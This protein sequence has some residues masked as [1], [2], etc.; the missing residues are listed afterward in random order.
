MT[1]A[2]ALPVQPVA[3]ETLKCHRVLAVDQNA[4]S[5]GR[6]RAVN[7][8]CWAGQ[9]SMSPG[10]RDLRPCLV[11]TGDQVCQACL[12]TASTATMCEVAVNQKLTSTRSFC[13]V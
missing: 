8:C 9:R 12:I 11:P 1:G 7:Q 13:I 10:P 6:D 5:V 2:M 3:M 4:I